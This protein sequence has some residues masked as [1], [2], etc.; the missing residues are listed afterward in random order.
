MRCVR[1]AIF[2]TLLS[3]VV[4]SAVN[5][6]WQGAVWNTT[7]AEAN[8]AFKV[9]H[10]PATPAEYQNYFNRAL[11]AFDR[12]EVGDL[13]FHK[14]VLIFEEGTLKEI[15]MSLIDAG[16]CDKLLEILRLQYG[17][18]AK[19]NER[20]KYGRSVTWNDPK[21]RNKV[22]LSDRRY[23]D[24]PFLEDDCDL[25]YDPFIPAAPGQL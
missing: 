22:T 5:A 1:L 13:T 9:P 17:E 24:A 2:F 8:R 20:G 14:G 10:R 7:P 3:V 12:Y 18:P 6:D 11:F 15:R 19:D 21:Q 25:V 23:P 16:K 4:S